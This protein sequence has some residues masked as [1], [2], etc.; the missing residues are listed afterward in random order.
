MVDGLSP[1]GAALLAD[2][3]SDYHS[4]DCRRLAGMLAAKVY[5]PR[6]ASLFR[7]LSTHCGFCSKLNKMTY[8]AEMGPIGKNR[9]GTAFT[10]ERVAMD[11]LGPYFCF[12]DGRRSVHYAA[13]VIC[14]S[15][16]VVAVFL[17]DNLSLSSFIMVVDRIEAR[18]GPLKSVRLDGMASH[19][20]YHARSQQLSLIHI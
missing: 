2:L 19:T 5:V 14:E 9:V 20:A 6:A 18:F 15:T 1:L 3:H 17:A 8:I 13:V 7:H 12:T 10:L 4:Y 11:W 16:G